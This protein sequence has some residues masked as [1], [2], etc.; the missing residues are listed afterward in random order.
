MT[1]DELKMHED[2]IKLKEDDITDTLKSIES[3]HVKS[4]LVI[5]FSATFF[6]IVFDKLESFPFCAALSIAISLLGAVGAALYNMWSKTVAI[7]TNLDDLITGIKKPSNWEQ[8][9]TYKY[10]HLTIKYGNAKTLLKD[11]AWWTKLSFTLLG[12]ALLLLIIFQFTHG[13]T[14]HKSNQTNFRPTHEWRFE[15]PDWQHRFWK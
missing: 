4:S 8:Y 5:V 1:P 6:G 12:L 7:H 11:K 2:A 14:Y 9:I 13:Q 3:E 10:E 15:R